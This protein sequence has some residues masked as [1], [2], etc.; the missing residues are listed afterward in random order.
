MRKTRSDE[1]Y[2]DYDASKQCEKSMIKIFRKQ[3]NC[4]KEISSK[5]ELPFFTGYFTDLIIRD[6]EQ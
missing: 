2:L 6:A 3:T 4:I 5:L 1:S